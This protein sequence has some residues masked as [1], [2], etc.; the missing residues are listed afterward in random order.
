VGQGVVREFGPLRV[1]ASLNDI[2]DVRQNP[3]SI[4]QGDIDTDVVNKWETRV[5]RL[6]L[7]YRFGNQKIKKARR[8]GTA[9]DD[10]H[11]RAGD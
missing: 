10:L 8:R 6:N 2:F 7:S 1:Q 9:S 4:Q 5:F 3:V 11:Q